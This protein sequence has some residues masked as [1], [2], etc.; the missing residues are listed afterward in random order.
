MES[1]FRPL[2]EGRTVYVEQMPGFLPEDFSAHFPLFLTHQSILIVFAELLFIRPISELL[3]M[4]ILLE[5]S[6]EETTRRLYE[7]PGGER[8]DP[9]FT[10]QYMKREGRIYA[11]YLADHKVKENVMIRVNAN[12]EKALKLN[13][14]VAA[15]LN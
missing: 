14:A 13:T 6:P 3:D 7:I 12:Q 10:E 5:V 1:V 2:K 8:F 15:P 11:G 9:K 4:S